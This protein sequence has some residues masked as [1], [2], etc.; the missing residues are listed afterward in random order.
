MGRPHVQIDTPNEQD[1]LRRHLEGTL[2]DLIK[3]PGVIGITLNGGLARGFADELSEIDLTL[4]LETGTYVDWEHGRSPIP[5]GIAMLDG[6]LYDLK[7]VDYATEAGREWDQVERWDFSYAEDLYDPQ[8]ALAA[9]REA[10][11]SPPEP[12]EAAGPLFSAWW[13]FE[14][15]GN[16]WLR[17]KDALQGHLV[18]NH[19]VEDLLTALFLANREFVPHVKWLIHMSRSLAWTPAAWPAR[20]AAALS[21]SPTLESLAARQAAI[22]GLW[23]EID[24]HVLGL[25][26]PAFPLNVMQRAHY[27]QLKRLAIAGSL[28]RAEWKAEAGL[29]L[30][31]SAPFHGIAV[32]DGE[33]VRLDTDAFLSAGPESMYAWHYAI[34]ESVREATRANF[35]SSQPEST[36]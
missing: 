32:F 26:D 30:L 18:L 27:I 28:S 21:V 15:A 33:T 9:L 12:D 19:A 11:L 34:L 29:N 25:I 2:P 6:M 31:N 1:R 16:I 4:Y 8:G 3:L 17:R 7:A 24:R 10:K 5:Q 23:A 36:P 22:G 20:L 35:D 13:H 14:L